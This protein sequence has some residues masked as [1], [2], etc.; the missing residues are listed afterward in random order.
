MLAAECYK[1]RMERGLTLLEFN[2]MV[3]QAYDFLQL[4]KNH[5]CRLQMGGVSDMKFPEG[6]LVMMVKRGNS[7]I[8]PNGKLELQIGDK[9]LTIARQKG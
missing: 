7:F 1:Q 2:Y 3:M 5:G 9:L 8:V 4:F 6:M